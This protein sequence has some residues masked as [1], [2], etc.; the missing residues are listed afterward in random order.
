MY[1]EIMY[2]FKLI[3]FLDK[4]NTLEKLR[5]NTE[6]VKFEKLAGLSLGHFGLPQD[7]TRTKT[8][9]DETW[10]FFEEIRGV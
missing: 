1:K 3:F 8:K 6:V 9:R 4:I 10:Y 2:F 7:A 5:Q